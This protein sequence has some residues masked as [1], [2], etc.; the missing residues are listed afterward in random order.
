MP[1]SLLP[2]AAGRDKLE[3]FQL[4]CQLAE[5]VEMMSTAQ[6]RS[7][8]A[9]SGI[10]SSPSGPKRG[11]VPEVG[12]AHHP[13]P[14]TLPSL[15]F[16]WLHDEQV[17]HDDVLEDDDDG[18]AGRSSRTI[19]S[20]AHRMYNPAIGN[21]VSVLAG[22]FLL[23]RS[24]VELAKLNDVRVVEVMAGALEVRGLAC[25]ECQEAFNATLFPN[26][27]PWFSVRS[28]ARTPQPAHMHLLQMQSQ[29]SV[30]A[31]RTRLTI[32]A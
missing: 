9:P 6:V 1:G 24:S 12:S 30:R 3:V 18:K 23:A 21:K 4:Q 15:A 22:D 13:P 26:T 10:S 17:I 29:Q 31:T 27:R 19:G 14:C 2:Q 32:K 7:P 25:L 8:N 28:S 16:T 20:L 5:I 11:S